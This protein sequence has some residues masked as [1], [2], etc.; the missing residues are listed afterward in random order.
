MM[1]K[2]PA[3]GTTAQDTKGRIWWDTN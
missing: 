3:Y 2:D 1:T